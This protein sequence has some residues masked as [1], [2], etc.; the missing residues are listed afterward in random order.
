MSIP[1]VIADASS[2]GLYDVNLSPIVSS[3]FP[4]SDTGMPKSVDGING[5]A[6]L[7]STPSTGAQ[8]AF[9]FRWRPARGH[10]SSK[11]YRACFQA[12]DTLGLLAGAKNMAGRSVCLRMLVEKCQ[13]CVQPG[14]SIGSI[15][16]QY[17]TDWLHIYTANPTVVDPDNLVPYTRINTGVLYTVQQ[18]DTAASLSRRFSATVASLQTVNP[19]IA[20]DKDPLVVGQQFCVLP[21]VCEV[22]CVHG[23]DC[24]PLLQ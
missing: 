5:Q 10:E 9:E 23:S 11:A 18:G 16:T 12:V 2:S 6:S 14:E 1:I 24:V 13:Y 20:L 3:S 7:V 22:T 21:P 8:K 4:P 17:N 19:D 15:A